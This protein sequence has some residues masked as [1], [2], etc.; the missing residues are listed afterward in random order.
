MSN[1]ASARW[2]VPEAITHLYYSPVY[3][4]L[5]HRQKLAYNRLHA[6]YLCEMFVYFEQ[7][8][9]GYYVKAAARPGVPEDLRD[10]VR[11][12]QYAERRHAEMFRKLARHLSPELYTEFRFHFI[13]LPRAASA[14]MRAACERPALFPAIFWIVLMQEERAVFYANQILDQSA[15][16]DPEMVEAQRLHLADEAG[17]LGVDEALLALYWD[18][19][20]PWV[21]R[22]NGRLLRLVVSE[23][24]VAPKRGGVRLVERWVRECPELEARRTELAAAMRRLAAEPR[25]H[26]SLYSR[27]IVPRTFAL[28]DR[29]EELHSLGKSLWAYSPEAAS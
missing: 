7:T 9:P 6:C 22:L 11:A 5:S 24:L 2:F 21:R 1:V 10:G 20:R 26:E 29:Y 12:L 3:D 15:G 13:R 17:H 27:R 4:T 16:L 19:N 18:A 8:L 23:F 14:V 28:F 25:F